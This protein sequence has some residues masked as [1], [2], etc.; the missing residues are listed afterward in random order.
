MQN[1][2][3]EATRDL[4]VE[5]LNEFGFVDIAYNS[6]PCTTNGCSFYVYAKAF[7]NNETVKFRTSDHSVTNSSRIL[8][9]IHLNDIDSVNRWFLSLEKSRNPERF[10]KVVKTIIQDIADVQQDHLQS[11]D[12]VTG[13][14]TT[15]KGSIRYNV[16]RTTILDIVTDVRA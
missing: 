4:L 6:M 16:T 15:K 5:K 11:G 2:E 12:V 1:T 13:T 14:R 9:E 3:L 10:V 8:G 7:T